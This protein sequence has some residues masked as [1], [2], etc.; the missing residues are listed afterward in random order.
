M[1]RKLTQWSK[2]T[3]TVKEAATYLRSNAKALARLSKHTQRIHGLQFK[4]STPDVRCFH[5]ALNLMGIE[6]ISAGRDTDTKRCWLYRIETCADIE[7]RI[8]AMLAS[9]KCEG[10]SPDDYRAQL[11]ADTLDE[12]L[13][14]VSS[15]ITQ[16]YES[17]L[18]SWQKIA[19]AFIQLGCPELQLL[20]NL[21]TEV[22][23][24]AVPLVI[25]QGMRA[26]KTA[27][28]LQ[29]IAE[30]STREQ[31][32]QAWDELIQVDKLAAL[33]VEQLTAA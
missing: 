29:R 15:H 32:Q 19:K 11:R 30:F 22:L 6:I 18:P 12:L 20:N 17:A 28:D 24:E 3:A 5:K 27:N 4:D 14:Q 13:Q 23:D 16:R 7:A 31:R 33:R 21:S 10:P 26:A 8:T 1:S 9:D 25:L 2:Q